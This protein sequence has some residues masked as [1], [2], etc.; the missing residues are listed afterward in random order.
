[1]RPQLSHNRKPPFLICRRGPIKL[2]QGYLS[3][4]KLLKRILHSMTKLVTKGATNREASREGVWDETERI[5]MQLSSSL[6]WKLGKVPCLP[7]ASALESGAGDHWQVR[8]FTLF[9]FWR[10]LPASPTLKKMLDLLPL[11]EACAGP[12]AIPPHTHPRLFHLH[13]GSWPCLPP[14]GGLGAHSAPG[15][16]PD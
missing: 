15:N 10:S 2:S 9:P 11:L 1:M 14:A 7:K 16:S 5:E 4:P 8:G 6:T 3:I 12:L 13:P